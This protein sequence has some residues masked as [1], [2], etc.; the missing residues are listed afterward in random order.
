MHTYIQHTAV[1]ITLRKRF[2]GLALAY[3]F[4]FRHK[5]MNLRELY[6]HKSSV[7]H[8]VPHADL[9]ELNRL[10][11]T[12]K[13]SPSPKH[14]KDFGICSG[15]SLQLLTRSTIFTSFVALRQHAHP[16]KPTNIYFLHRISNFFNSLEPSNYVQSN[17]SR[18]LVQTKRYEL[19]RV[20]MVYWEVGTLFVGAAPTTSH[21]VRVSRLAMSS[22]YRRDICQR[23]KGMK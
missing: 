6:I 13:V 3:G 9:R 19:S 23:K 10:R 22:R 18:P 4:E 21:A 11:Q 17:T 15:K 16:H 14:R 2:R 20:M 8:S 5:S 7:S 12:S 1:H